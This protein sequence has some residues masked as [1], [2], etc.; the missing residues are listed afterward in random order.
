MPVSAICGREDVMSQCSPEKDPDELVKFNGGT[1]SSHPASMLAGYTFLTYLKEHADEI[2]PKIG[3]MG[4]IARKGIEEIFN[5]HGFKV[6]CTGYPDGIA[7]GSSLLGV[8]FLK[9]SVE[10]IDSPDQA[11]NPE[12]CDIELRE[13]IFKLK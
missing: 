3:R 7:E 8:H 11:W 5:T 9:D 1:Y 6:K 10:C 12:I 4:K 13:E 2:Y